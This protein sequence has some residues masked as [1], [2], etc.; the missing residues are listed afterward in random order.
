VQVEPGVND[1]TPTDWT[2]RKVDSSQ[3]NAA[4]FH[5]SHAEATRVLIDVLRPGDCAPDA[6]FV[7][8]KEIPIVILD[9]LD[10]Y[11]AGESKTHLPLTG[12]R[13][14]VEGDTVAEAK[15]ALADD[16]AAQLRLLLLLSSSHKG[17]IA[18][19]LLQN[20]EYL[21]SC[22]EPGSGGGRSKKG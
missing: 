7:V 13:V 21:K 18:P 16:L 12:V 2:W 11:W 6:N 17:K 9:S 4:V 15:R 10:K 19:A 3:P 22:M 8:S 14:P 1:A 20:L 5:I